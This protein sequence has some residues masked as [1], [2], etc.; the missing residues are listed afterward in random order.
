[1]RV[2]FYAFTAPLNFPRTYPFPWPNHMQ[3]EGCARYARGGATN[4]AET[5]LPPSSND[6]CRNCSFQSP[7]CVTCP[8]KLSTIVVVRYAAFARIGFP[9]CKTVAILNVSTGA[10]IHGMSCIQANRFL[11]N[12]MGVSLK[13]LSW[14]LTLFF[15]SLTLPI[16][17]HANQHNNTL[18][19]IIIS[20]HSKPPLHSSYQTPPL[21]NHQSSQQTRL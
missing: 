17:I 18:L 11:E 5:Q 12:E 6:A 2:G 20:H 9:F 7:L 3:R 10:K 1:M 21:H 19:S 16:F 8:I 13:G 4:H 14:Y 15:L